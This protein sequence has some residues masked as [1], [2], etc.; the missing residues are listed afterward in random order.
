VERRKQ[1]RRERVRGSGFRKRKGLSGTRTGQ[2]NF[3]ANFV[4]QAPNEVSAKV[5]D[6]D[7]RQQ[8]PEP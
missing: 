4:D 3:V 6:E 5:S 8:N 1:A 2:R 7:H